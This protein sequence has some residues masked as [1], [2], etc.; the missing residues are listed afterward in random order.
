MGSDR[1]YTGYSLK[2]IW[3]RKI[4]LIWFSQW[5][6]YT[7]TEVSTQAWVQSIF[8]NI[9]YRSSV[10]KRFIE[11]GMWDLLRNR[12]GFQNS[13]SKHEKETQNRRHKMG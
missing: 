12:R 13:I 9:F 4:I 10:N 1:C 8:L 7:F 3:N 2:F 6:D 5:S 11:M